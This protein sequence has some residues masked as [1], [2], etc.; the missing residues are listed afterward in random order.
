MTLGRTSVSLNRIVVER[1]LEELEGDRDETLLYLRSMELKLDVQRLSPSKSALA[2]TLHVQADRTIARRRGIFWKM[3]TEK[4]DSHVVTM[5]MTT[6]TRMKSMK[7]NEMNRI[8]CALCRWRK[9][10]STLYNGARCYRVPCER[11]T[12]GC[13]CMPMHSTPS[14]IRRS[15]ICSLRSDNN[16]FFDSPDKYSLRNLYECIVVVYSGQILIRSIRLLYDILVDHTIPL[17]TC[18]RDALREVLFYSTLAT[19]NNAVPLDERV[20]S[21]VREV[22]DPIL[23]TFRRGQRRQQLVLRLGQVGLELR[24]DSKLATLFVDSDP[25]TNW[26]GKP[27]TLDVVVQMAEDMHF[28]FTHTSYRRDLKR[29]M[30]QRHDHLYR[31]QSRFRRSWREKNYEGY[32]DEDEEGNNSD[33]SAASDEIMLVVD[34]VYYAKIDALKKVLPPLD[35]RASEVLAR[36]QAQG[37]GD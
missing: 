1:S 30:S 15:L 2:A 12:A 26:K 25:A 19:K 33:D 8:S 7:T 18:F 13:F 27:L 29:D 10:T 3:D 14:C 22:T 36:V 21:L 23:A 35:V 16:I 31:V 17:E 24:R 28:L 32:S 6:M 5:E 11:V 34:V 37:A 4:D 9:F 20:A